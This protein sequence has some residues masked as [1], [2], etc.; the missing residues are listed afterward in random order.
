M[1]PVG[2][3]GV[4]EVNWTDSLGTSGTLQFTGIPGPD[5]D[6][7]RLGI[8]SN[9]GETLASV[10][11]T[12][13]A[14]RASTSSSRCEFSAPGIPPSIPEP[15]TWAMMLLGFVGLSYA[16]YRRATTTR[17]ALI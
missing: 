12:T 7:N 5:T 6:F 16:G 10:A 2:D 9:D 13:A 17:A 8:V 14:G 3:V 1:H 11:I 4:I 15:S